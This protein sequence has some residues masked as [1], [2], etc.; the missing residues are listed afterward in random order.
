MRPE[1][2]EN[3]ARK[4]GALGEPHLYQQ[5]AL[6]RKRGGSLFC[7]PQPEREVRVRE[8]Q[9]TEKDTAGLTPWQGGGKI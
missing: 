7:G 3:N 5:E 9:R 2:G 8:T 1:K 6:W 4:K